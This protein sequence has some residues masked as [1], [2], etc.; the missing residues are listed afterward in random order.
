M[1]TALQ[2]QDLD[3]GHLR[4]AADL[5]ATALPPGLTTALGSRWLQAYYR[6]FADSPYG[7]ALLA[8]LDGQPVGVL[9]GTTDTAAHRAWTRRASRRRL[10]SLGLLAVV[11]RP[12]LAAL[13]LRRGGQRLA[14]RLRRR[15]SQEP[16]P[17][18]TAV[19]AY[20]AVAPPARGLG[21]G[22]ALVEGFVREAALAG[23]REAMLVTL[24]GDAG[25]GRFY[26][27]LGWRYVTNH[28]NAEGHLV[29]RYMLTLAS[30]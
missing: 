2:L 3:A 19:L 18:K 13:L 14:G 26:E 4:F 6:S 24:A 16:T 5:H 22:A 25:A 30:H 9:A 15:P 1:S 21:V 27:R 29:G 8:T 20:L 23:A 11:R 7:I 28:R 12:L 17:T 10:V